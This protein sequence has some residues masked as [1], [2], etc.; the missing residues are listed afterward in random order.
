M[1]P[2]AQATAMPPPA[3]PVASGLRPMPRALAATPAPVTRAELGLGGGGAALAAA[4]ASSS[5]VFRRDRLLREHA[6][7]ATL[8]DLTGC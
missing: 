2:T 5:A 6:N 8:G 7:L 1:L 3:M 4:A